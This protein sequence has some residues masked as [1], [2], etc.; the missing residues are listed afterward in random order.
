MD[1]D[2]SGTDGADN[3]GSGGDLHG[4][5][6]IASYL[7][8]SVRAAQRWEEDLG[9]PVHRLKTSA[10][11]SILARRAE[12]DEW[13][14]R[15]TVLPGEAQPPVRGEGTTRIRPL[16]LGLAA[17]L[18][19]VLMAV[20]V[21]TFQASRRA[22][23][24]PATSFAFTTDA[25]E[26]R[27][28][29]GELVWRYAFPRPV[30]AER[31]PGVVQNNLPPERILVTDLDGDGQPG[32]LVVVA[33]QDERSHSDELYYFSMAGELRWTYRPG[34]EMLF[35]SETFAPPWYI[36]AIEI[37]EAPASEAGHVYLTVLHHYWWPS[38]VVRLEPDG[39]ADTVMVHSGHLYNLMRFEHEGRAYLAAGGINNEFAA[40]SF[41]IL[42]EGDVPVRSPQVTGSEFECRECPESPPLR[43]FV[44]PR[45]EVGRVSDSPYS[46][47]AGGQVTGDLLRVYTRE[48]LYSFAADTVFRMT[49]GGDVLDAHTTDGYWQA[50]RRYEGMGRIDHPARD[51]PER[52]REVRIFERD[53]GWTTRHV[54]FGGP[55]PG[56]ARP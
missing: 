8:K 38:A 47:T 40:A 43:Y 33:F 49:P 5:K 41:A 45:A 37:V 1:S 17:G 12:I 52:Q 34:M 14:R 18:V 24:G 46:R 19:A 56:G 26:A 55:V 50:H 20:G 32:V 36:G 53:S 7:G 3:G 9:L 13:R 51:C 21:L 6:E 29:S 2:R 28:A 48:D 31:A 15:L 23:P 54:P 42:A 27:D 22:V 35:G 11:Q 4:W 30:L 16:H 25:L 10:G 39:T 44:F